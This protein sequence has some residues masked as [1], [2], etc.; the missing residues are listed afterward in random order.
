MGKR[1]NF[2]FQY[3][4]ALRAN[5]HYGTSKHENKIAWKKE[6]SDKGLPF[7]QMKGI[8]AKTSYSGYCHVCD[9]FSRYIIKNHGECKSFN[10]GRKYVEE[11]LQLKFDKGLSAWTLHTYG[12]ALACA[13]GIRLIDINFDFPI[14]SREDI[15]RC[16]N[17][18]YDY[19]DMDKKYDIVRDFVRG[20]GARRGGLLALRKEDIRQRADG[21]YEV[22]LREKGG[23]E[24]WA[25]VHPD[26]KDTVLKVFESS[27]GFKTPNGEE[28][29][30]ARSDLPKGRIHDCRAEHAAL[31][32]DYFKE[33]GY[34]SGN[35][36]YCRKELYGIS[37]DKGIMKAISEQLG[38]S[39]LGVVVSYLYT[40]K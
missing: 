33:H 14:R 37:Y 10:D 1:A 22:F 27:K 28:R 5:T 31:M 7:Q 25:I 23:K 36:Y 19:R 9:Q 11:W 20:T 2:K 18:I 38:H 24:R 40:K 17:E 13:Y 29:V 6:L 16:R 3:Q 21:E 30:F 8:Y 15:I 34:E 32:Y 26:Y 35:I 12:S 39:R 4:N